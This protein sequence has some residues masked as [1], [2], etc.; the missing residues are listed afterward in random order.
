M[1]YSLSE[2]NYDPTTMYTVL[3]SS[4]VAAERAL[5]AVWLTVTMFDTAEAPVIPAVALT[6]LLA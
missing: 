1:R 3:L 6:T 2:Q 4:A 5:Y